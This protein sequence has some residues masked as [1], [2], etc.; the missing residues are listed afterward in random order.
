MT[1]HVDAEDLMARHNEVVALSHDGEDVVLV[2][3]GNPILK[4]SAV[5]QHRST[6]NEAALATIREG[7]KGL[8]KVTIKEILAWRDEARRG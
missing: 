6:K 3:D 5:P 1:V 8:P 2:Q 7:R 4:L